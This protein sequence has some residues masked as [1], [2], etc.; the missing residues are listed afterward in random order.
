MYDVQYGPEARRQQRVFVSGPY[1]SRL[2]SD[3]V[4]LF[5]FG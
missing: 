5:V 1:G 4:K 3:G 2:F